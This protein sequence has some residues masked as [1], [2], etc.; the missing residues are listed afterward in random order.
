MIKLIEQFVFYILTLA[1]VFIVMY[2]C[3]KSTIPLI[4]KPTCEGYKTYFNGCWCHTSDST[5]TTINLTRE[6][7]K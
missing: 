4:T 5:F 2:G 1:T 3:F 6:Q 7:C